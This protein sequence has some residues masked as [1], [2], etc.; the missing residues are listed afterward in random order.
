MYIHSDQ[1]LHQNSETMGRTEYRHLHSPWLAC[2]PFGLKKPGRFSS[3]YPSV[4]YCIQQE[5]ARPSMVLEIFQ[6]AAGFRS[7]D[8]LLL[9]LEIVHPD[10]PRRDEAVGG[11]VL[12]TVSCEQIF[13]GRVKESML[14]LFLLF[15]DRFVATTG[16][17]LDWM[18]VWFVI[19]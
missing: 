12:N 6:T 11:L 5:T 2:A 17:L 15:V 14:G 4:C 19:D 3:I 8:D 7:S 10:P 18:Y 9:K 13:H 16:P 1:V